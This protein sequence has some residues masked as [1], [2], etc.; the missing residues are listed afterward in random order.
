MPICGGSTQ[1]SDWHNNVSTHTMR[2]T[3]IPEITNETFLEDVLKGLS[4]PG[5]YLESKY[6]YDKR[7]DA[8]FQEIMN[9][10][11]YYPTRCEMEILSRQTPQI[12]ALIR[13]HFSNG[14]DVVEMG[15]GDATKSVH[16]LRYLQQGKTDFRYYPIDISSNV[17]SLLESSLP[18]EVPGIKVHGL[19]G[20]YFEMLDRAKRLSFREKVVMFLG[21]NIGNIPL[22]QVA[23]FCKDLRSHLSTGD[24]LLIGF[25]LK[26]D[27]ELILSAY[28][29]AQGITRRF[30]LNLL[31]RINRELGADFDLSGFEHRPEYNAQ[32]GACKSY[33]VSTRDQRVCIAGMHEIYFEEGEPIYMEIS[34]KYSPEQTD[35]LARATG[36]RPLRH[37]Y[38]SKGYFIDAAWLCV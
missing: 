25:D 35:E 10:P 28:N 23:A 8:I 30:N 5:K 33:L 2:R 4:A 37:F 38:D 34:Q 9:C 15:A 16:L 3:V 11:E 1:A 18:D 36:F 22:E 31:R 20:E 13:S 27:P 17:I 12:S 14:F 21:A 26:K 7:G 6:F 19:N 24:L 29:D 32:T